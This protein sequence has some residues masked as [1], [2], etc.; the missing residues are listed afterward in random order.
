MTVPAKSLRQAAAPALFRLLSD[1]ALSRAALG[2]CAVPVALLD[3]E[4]KNRPLIYVNSAFESFFGYREGEVLGR[5][6]A[7][8][9]FRGDEQLASRLLAEPS[10][11]W[12]L[13]AWSKDGEP[14]HVEVALGALHSAD[15]RLTH[16]VAAFSD[17]A[18]VERLRAELESLKSLSAA[19]LNVR[20]D[21]GG[22]PAR[23]AQQSGVK[24]APADELNAD[25]QTG[26]IVHQR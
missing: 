26:C 16:W 21:A 3:A 5:S 12:Q 23:R 25:R 8:A 17:R 14:R 9:L 10:R 13:S 22:E 18:E 19:S 1:S 6:L 11:R 2:L 20:L 15:G 4:A 7:G 24:V